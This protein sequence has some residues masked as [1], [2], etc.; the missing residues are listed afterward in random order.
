MAIPDTT[1]F[2]AILDNLQ[3]NFDDDR[4]LENFR[5]WAHADV[6]FYLGTTIPVPDGS[7]GESPGF[8]SMGDNQRTKAT[9]AFSIWNEL[10]TD[11]NLVAVAGPDGAD[12][13]FAYSTRT[14]NGGTYAAPTLGALISRLGYGTREIEHQAIW[15]AAS[16][17]WPQLAEGMV[18]FGSIGFETYLHEIG[19][20]LGLSHPGPYDAN[21]TPP[22]NYAD[23]ARFPSDSRQYT[24]MSY[25]GGYLPGSGWAPTTATNF[26]N[27]PGSLGAS[28]PMLYDIAAIQLKYGADFTTRSGDTT[29]GYN[30]LNAGWDFFDFTKTTQ[31]IFTIW[32]GGGLDTLDASGFNRNQT[33]NLTPGSFS[34]LLGMTE[35][36]AI[37][38]NVGPD[39]RRVLIENAVGGGGDD[40][41]TGNF[42]DNTLRGG[43]GNDTIR[44]GTGRDS[45]LGGNGFDI[46]DG[47]GAGTLGPDGV[48]LLTGGAGRDTFVYA[49]GYGRSTV[50]DFSARERL[51]L[52]G[53]AVHS[54]TELMA[55]A[56]QVGPDLVFDFSLP[57]SSTVDVL[58]LQGFRRG[59]LDADLVSFS[60]DP[61]SP[62]GD[63]L[64]LP[65]PGPGLSA[66][67]RTGIARLGDGGFVVLE[68]TAATFANQ[69]LMAHRFDA[70]GVDTGELFQIN[71]TPF[72]TGHDLE[73]RVASI[74][75]GNFVVLWTSD[76]NDGDIRSLRAR[77]F[78]E[79]ARP[80]G[81]DF[82]VNVT[83][84][85]S[86]ATGGNGIANQGLRVNAS[87]SFTVTWTADILPGS[88]SFQ[89]HLFSRNFG[90][91]G[92]A[93]AEV[94]LGPPLGPFDQSFSRTYPLAGGGSVRT[95]V[96]PIPGPVTGNY[97]AFAELPG[98][99]GGQRVQ[100]D[101]NGLIV[102]QEVSVAQL[103]DG[104][105]AF[106]WN[107]GTLSGFAQTFRG[108][109][110]V[111]LDSDLR[112]FTRPGSRGD[113]LLAGGADNDRLF[114]L[115][116]NDTLV[117]G[118][119]ADALDGGP[120]RDL[121][122]YAVSLGAVRVQLFD[123]GPQSGGHAEGDVLV[124]IEDL[125]GS[126][127]DDVLS[128]SAARNAISG[129]FGDD[130][131]TGIGTPGLTGDILRGDAG[132]DSLQGG[133]GADQL[134]GGDGSD[135]LRG[136]TGDDVFEIRRGE[137][138]GDSIG[139]FERAGAVGGDLIVFRGFA[140]GA[141]LQEVQPGLYAILVSGE[142]AERFTMTAGLPLVA[143]EDYVFR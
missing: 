105:I 12:I 124:A 36:V 108:G 38:Y 11:I 137:A 59:A 87:G 58:T 33:I 41:I 26:S 1:S 42:G 81:D 49:R 55:K 50:T 13:T 78:D 60:E 62:P 116:G 126:A 92:N 142:E 27:V 101:T 99:P 140:A 71:T 79:K 95:W 91:G 113:D 89:S 77:I 67:L 104:R 86:I 88:V 61:V 123:P 135:A 3:G 46:L 115:A 119:G 134:F 120:G 65:N 82:T 53:A 21:D 112:G 31:P 9:E 122:T 15:M 52:T 90:P 47:G 111:I 8:V 51:D 107:D 114:G 32:D 127:Y 43:D 56:R 54:F 48:D 44:G 14:N 85:E 16:A 23:D 30:M 75:R 34:S 10:V 68:Q 69:A 80:L 110:M 84:P 45:L 6:T 139:D 106:G 39:P 83:P 24:I 136:G 57:G 98:V 70:R 37:A 66:P 28:T 73:M 130:T 103:A 40:S 125:V 63:F 93:G 97:H 2:N 17:G 141:V 18:A 4:P 128:G 118:R 19:H 100:L 129:G 29:Y 102:P 138:E 20:A 94:D 132:D 22:P 7:F 72:G 64:V 35:N 74:G 96:E 133:A 5:R 121:A 76:D 131:I 25:F 117:G 143:G 109:G